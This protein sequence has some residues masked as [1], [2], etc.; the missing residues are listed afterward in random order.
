MNSEKIMLVRS[1]WQQ[2]LP[3]KET[4]ADLFYGQLFELDPSLRKMFKGDMVEQ[5]RKLMVM[6]NAV[7]N[8]LDN[9]A[10]LL[11]TIE[12]MGRR[13]VAYGVT[14]A[15]YDTV[16]NALIWT[17]GQGLGAKFTPA[18]KDAWLE[19]YTTLASAMKQVAYGES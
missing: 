1:S 12:D 2:V 14:A 18:V 11:K 8:S 16:G 3:I 6:L 5:G 13:H 19:A 4:A 10:P 17:L 15:H 7:V 9:L